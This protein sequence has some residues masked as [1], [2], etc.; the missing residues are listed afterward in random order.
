MTKAVTKRLGEATTEGLEEVSQGIISSTPNNYTDYNTFNESMFNPEK[1]ETVSNLWTALGNSFSEALQDPNAGVEFATGFLTGIIGIPRV[2]RGGFPITL[3]NNIVAGLREDYRNIQEK[4]SIIDEI[5]ERLQNDTKINEY[6]NGLVRNFSIQEDMNRALAE[7]DKFNY[8]NAESAQLIS[9]IRM[10]DN[11]GEIKRLREIVNNSIDMSDEGITNIINS[12]PQFKNMTIEEVR[13][14]LE[15]KRNTINSTI[16]TYLKDKKSLEANNPNITNETLENAIFLK[17]Q[18]RNLS[19]RYTE[20]LGDFYDKF[21]ILRQEYYDTHKNAEA[22]EV[23]RNSIVR[24]YVLDDK[25][26]KLIHSIIANDNSSISIDERKDL[27]DKF[28][29][30]IKI[31]TSLKQIDKSLKEILDNPSKSIQDLYTTIRNVESK[32]LSRQSRELEGR[33]SEATDSKEFK[34]I[35]L[36]SNTTDPYIISHAV[37]NLVRSGNQL[38]INHKKRE[39]L[40]RLSKAFINNSKEE[41][42]IKSEAIRL[43]EDYIN[44]GNEV[45]KDVVNTILEDY[46]NTSNLDIE[47]LRYSLD[48][49]VN[50]SLNR[51]K[52]IKDLA[53]YIPTNV[54]KPKKQSTQQQSTN[55]NSQNNTVSEDDTFDNIITDNDTLNNST[56]YTENNGNYIKPE[57]SQVDIAAAKEGDY[58]LFNEVAKEKYGKNYDTIYKYLEDNGAFEYVNK[59]NLKPG[60]KIGF[61]IDES[62]GSSVKNESWYKEPVI[63]MV[64]LKEDGSTQVVGVLGSNTK[65]T[66]LENLRKRI[67]D[68]YKPSDSETQFISSQ[69]TNVS[70][71]MVGKVP[72]SKEEKDLST[73][74]GV[75]ENSKFGIIKNGILDTNESIEDS[76]VHKPLDMSNK[77]GRVYLLVKS[78]SGKYLPVAVRVKHFNKN[79]YNVEDVTKENTP[80]TK[81]L[82]NAIQALID[83]NENTFED[84]YGKLENLL[85]LSTKDKNV[86]NSIL[87]KDFADYRSDI[88]KYL[89]SQNPRIQ[90]D[91]NRLND[92]RYTK[93]LLNSDILTS[94]LIEA[95]VISEWF[96]T[97]YF[98]NEGKIHSA[99][100]PVGPY[101][102]NT[103]T[104]TTQTQVQQEVKGNTNDNSVVVENDV[105]G[106]KYT[107]VEEYEAIFDE[108]NQEITQT[109]P[110]S[111]VEYLLDV[112]H[113]ISHN[114]SYRGER[115]PDGKFFI[116]NDKRL[117]IN[118]ETQSIA[119]YD[120]TIKKYSQEEVKEDNKAVEENSEITGEDSTQ[121][122][123][124]EVT[125]SE[126][127]ESMSDLDALSIDDDIENLRRT[128]NDAYKVWDK[129]QEI[130]WLNKVLPQLSEQDRVKF[131]EGL[132][133]AANGDSA[134]GMFSKGIIT[135]SNIA[136]EGTTYHEAFHYVF[137]SLLDQNERS[138]LLREYSKNNLNLT[139]YELEELMAEDFRMYVQNGGVDN[140]SLG[141]KVLDFFKSLFIKVT[142]WDRFAPSSLYYF[143]KINNGSYSNKTDNYTK[144]LQSIKSKAIVNGTFMKAPNGNPSNLNEKQWLQVRTKAFKEWFGDW[145]NDPENASK[146]VDENNEPLVVYHGSLDNTFT[147]FDSSKIDKK[148]KGFFFTNSEGL[149]STYG[150][151]RAFFLNSREPYVV[152]GNG[153]N[154][155]K[156]NVKV[157]DLA[158]DT[159]DKVKL[160]RGKAKDHLDKGL[161]TKEQY[162]KLEENYFKYIDIYNNLGNTLEDESKKI[163]I[164]DS[165]S[166]LDTSLILERTDDVTLFLGYSNNNVSVI[167]KNITDIGGKKTKKGFPGV[168]NVYVVSN[169]NDIK[170]ATDN[171][172]TFDSNNPDIR[173][174]KV[175]NTSF[176]TLNKEEQNYLTKKGWT[177]ELF[178]SISQEE[179]DH[180]IKC[181]L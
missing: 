109:L 38:A 150:K 147:I 163:A 33:L 35:I 161:F 133:R 42:S 50:Y 15:K 175:S 179:R 158:K 180:A 170:S 165:L 118:I 13:E 18:F 69:I 43:L 25:K 135:L 65:F 51:I 159:I 21:E 16:D 85:F 57:I 152:E 140:R 96:T 70:K 63:F 5:N 2:K 146:V 8:K 126:L 17:S 36:N 155:N 1:R 77:E 122:T 53:A 105:T 27:N 129:E 32:G 178:D 166:K 49:A 174:R 128:T 130:Q 62:F 97:D 55:T 76:D 26:S 136:A 78:G 149:A 82:N 139:E 61:M 115:T 153:A 37:S 132:I 19:G 95:K 6:Y 4:Q 124:K 125:E 134:W 144:E 47:K 162:N 181:M 137:N 29:D 142:N 131:T 31:N 104:T 167:F 30:L 45:T 54:G 24:D 138:G 68:E 80:F 88:L 84:A 145:Q 20:L 168:N 72:F 73:V 164:I 93:L 110:N 66:G 154:F 108:N 103:E 39:S 7:G 74:P 12:S 23:T 87:K 107:V 28:G 169:P 102:R 111:T 41:D 94:N 58:R 10:F 92:S 116:F 112:A 91:L 151:T 117:I 52:K 100:N 113:A 123:P 44:N 3:E 67:L 172:G 106:E 59:G 119:P 46:E 160:L 120:E 173:Y 9:D 48:N 171:I 75:T 114:K 143:S 71:I 177:K 22:L 98:D 127:L 90:V 156:L 56:D 86:I 121:E 40:L 64:H 81:L 79:E 60:D 89:Y 157:S 101:D 14:V 99:E 34:D 141:R 11:I 148:R 176:E 83:S